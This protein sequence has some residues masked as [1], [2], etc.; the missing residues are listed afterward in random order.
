MTSVKDLS[1]RSLRT[2]ERF[3]YEIFSKKGV[4]IPK[5]KNIGIMST[6]IDEEI[7]LVCKIKRFMTEYELSLLFELDDIEKAIVELRVL[8]E[9]YQEVHIK[10]VRE[11]KELL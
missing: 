8:L 1:G 2:R 9:G 3:D 11:L 10:L 6:L 7:K 4:K 5:G